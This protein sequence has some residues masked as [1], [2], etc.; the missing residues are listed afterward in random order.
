MA[1]RRAAEFRKSRQA[2]SAPPQTLSC[3]YRWAPS[4]GC[5]AHRPHSEPAGASFPPATPRSHLYGGPWGTVA[6]GEGC[7]PHRHCT[8]VRLSRGGCSFQ[9]GRASAPRQFQHDTSSERTPLARISSPTSR[10]L[11]IVRQRA[12]GLRIQSG[13]L[14]QFGAPAAHV[15]ALVVSLGL[16]G[17]SHRDLSFQG[18]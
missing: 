7:L 17:E 6:P 5:R 10:R 13:R 14:R 4:E 16:T 3:S 18:K 15:I 1:L 8:P 9:F 11:L 2:P 12:P